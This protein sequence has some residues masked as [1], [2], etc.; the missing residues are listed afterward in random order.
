MERTSSV[1]TLLPSNKEQINSFVKKT[2]NELKEG[3]INAL[4]FYL[5]LKSAE[6]T[7]KK[8][9]DDKEVKEL[10]MSEAS[11]HGSK[12]FEYR[13]FEVE[14]SD[15]LGVKYDYSIC[16]DRVW[17]GLQAQ[18]R[19]LQ[20]RIK[21]R[22]AFLKALPSDNSVMDDEGVVLVPPLKKSSSGLRVTIK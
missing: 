16:N 17:D 21:E 14:S 6:T 9:I 1:I 13:G 10:A 8:I 2:V 4:D 19:N 7:I 18:L 3:G 20:E 11:K 5:Q 22:E 12:Q 15:N